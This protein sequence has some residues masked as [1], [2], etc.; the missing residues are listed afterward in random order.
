MWE[1]VQNITQL[2]FAISLK[3]DVDELRVYL[4]IFAPLN[5]SQTHELLDV[6]KF[7]EP[8][9]K[10]KREISLVVYHTLAANNSNYLSKRFSR[11]FCSHF[12]FLA[13]IVSE[14]QAHALYRVIA[15]MIFTPGGGGVTLKGECITAAHHTNITTLLVMGMFHF[16]YA[17]AWISLYCIYVEEKFV[18]Y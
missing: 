5:K 4:F 10:T 11:I 17:R 3:N 1:R 16:F 15:H 18:I 12:D 13:Y 9:K 8:K 7:I 14:N 2:F 6:Y